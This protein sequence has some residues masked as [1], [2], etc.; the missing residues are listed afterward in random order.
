MVFVM[1][2]VSAE[3]EVNK[4]TNT[5]LAVV[6]GPNLLWGQDAAMTLS[7]IGPINNFTR[8]LLDLHED[9][10]SQWKSVALPLYIIHT[11]VLFSFVLPN[12]WVCCKWVRLAGRKVAG[13]GFEETEGE[14][15]QDT[16]TVWWVFFCLFCFL[17]MTK[18]RQSVTCLSVYPAAI[19]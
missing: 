7:S 2:Q 3:S 1:V 14:F 11:I 13:T 15:F 9:V 8:V 19:M 4:M 16:Y 12:S 17:G 6:F 5:N 18:F 10:F